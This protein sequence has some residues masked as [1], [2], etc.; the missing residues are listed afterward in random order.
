M[1]WLNY[2][3]FG[4]GFKIC[5]NSR[6]IDFPENLPSSAIPDLGTNTDVGNLIIRFD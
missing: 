1:C 2:I 5:A 4:Y 6:I 3:L